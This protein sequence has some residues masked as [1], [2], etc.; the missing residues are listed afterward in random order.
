MPPL[1]VP[2]SGAVADLPMHAKRSLLWYCLQLCCPTS[3]PLPTSYPRHVTLVTSRYWKPVSLRLEITGARLGAH[4]RW[5]GLRKA[6]MQ[7]IAG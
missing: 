4:A 6:T 7:S 2:A 5:L 3:L 1:S